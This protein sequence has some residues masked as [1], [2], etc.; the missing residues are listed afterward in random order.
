M[1]LKLAI[2]L[3]FISWLLIILISVLINPLIIDSVTYIP[4][5]IPISIIIVTGILGTVYIREI[6][7]NETIEGFKLGIIFLIID[8]ICD[9]LIKYL[10][11]NHIFLLNDYK[12]HIIYTI[13]LTP[14][15]TTILGYLAETEIKLEG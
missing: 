14:I 6:N 7:K 3:G 8:I 10:T 5:I 11:N 2:V 4:I 12:V 1:K 9:L 15:I 13:I